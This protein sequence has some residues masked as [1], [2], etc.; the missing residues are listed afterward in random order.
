MRQEPRKPPAAV[1][2]DEWLSEQLRDRE[3]A[4]AYLNAALDD[5]DQA[6]F[7]L[8][9]RNVAKAL[10]GV[11]MLAR[12]TGMNRVALSRAL[13]VNGN[14]ELRNFTR[15]LEASGLRFV[16]AAKESARPVRGKA[17]ARSATR[18]SA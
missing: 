14:P 13:S 7:M 16:I 15:I 18:S 2:Q 17:H 12:I 9:L 5:G 10:G 1:P 8:A 6:S 11:A 3:L 4:V